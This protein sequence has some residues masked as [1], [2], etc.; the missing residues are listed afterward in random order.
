MNIEVTGNDEVVMGGGDAGKKR[1][2]FI[3]K[4]GEWLGVMSGRW[5]P[6]AVENS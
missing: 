4:C 5:W 1:R 6:V 2:E 3:K